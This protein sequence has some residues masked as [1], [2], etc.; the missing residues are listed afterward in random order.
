MHSHQSQKQA[1][2]GEK[3]EN[4]VKISFEHVASYLRIAF[5]KG[6]YLLVIVESPLS[7]NSDDHLG[8][9]RREL[10]LVRQHASVPKG[11]VGA[12]Q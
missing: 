1:V 5:V 11:Q 7:L 2:N 6:N 10:D 8:A 12:F 9:I 3:V 4:D